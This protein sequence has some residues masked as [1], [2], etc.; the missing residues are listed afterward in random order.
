MTKGKKEI[1][2]GRPGMPWR[3]WGIAI[4]CGVLVHALGLSLLRVNEIPEPPV[5]I[6]RPYAAI[7]D[8]ADGSLPDGSF[9][10]IA[11]LDTAPLFLPSRWNTTS[12]RLEEARARRPADLFDLY[13]P[14]LSFGDSPAAAE[15]SLRLE[16]VADPREQLLAGDRYP[17]GA[18]GRYEREP[19]GREERFARV[20]LYPVR[21]GDSRRGFDIPP[22]DL[23][24]ELTETRYPTDPALFTLQVTGAGSPGPLFLVESSGSDAIDGF[25]RRRIREWL[26]AE[27]FPGPGYYRI[28]AGP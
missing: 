19:P 21:G 27:G 25:L 15:L 28:E 14:E 22:G 8:G 17:F 13:S 26:A 4:A 23:P 3:F 24:E 16:Y 10:R 6:E 18:L 1:R 2:G 20:D 5:F 11:L 12:G 7:G 9:D